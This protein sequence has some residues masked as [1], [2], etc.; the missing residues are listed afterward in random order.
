[1]ARECVRV[2]VSDKLSIFLKVTILE[3]MKEFRKKINRVIRE[4]RMSALLRLDCE[5]RTKDVHML[6]VTKNMQAILK[7][8]ADRLKA[9]ET[10]LLEK[11]TEYV[12]QQTASRVEMLKASYKALLAQARSKRTENET[13]AAK[14]QILTKDVS[15]REQLKTLQGETNVPSS[16]EQGKKK[17]IIGGGGRN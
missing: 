4:E 12:T 15:Q 9:R 11:K 17:K 7:G 5:E 2:S 10:E 8:G 6:R 16:S 13:H 14:L 1:M 3:S